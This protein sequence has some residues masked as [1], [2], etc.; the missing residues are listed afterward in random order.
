[1]A[2]LSLHS[3]WNCLVILKI[4]KS[5]ILPVPSPSD[6]QYTYFPKHLGTKVPFHISFQHCIHEASRCAWEME[7]C[8]SPGMVKS[9]SQYRSLGDFSSAIFQ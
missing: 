7:Q 5:L 9:Q 2:G 1:M 8:H 4:I 3:Y 6:S